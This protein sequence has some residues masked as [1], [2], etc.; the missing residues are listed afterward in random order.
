VNNFSYT[1]VVD[2]RDATTDHSVHGN[3][4]AQ[5]DVHQWF[6]NEAVIASGDHALVSS[7]DLNVHDSH[8]MTDS[9]N[10][11]NSLD[12]ATGTGSWAGAGP[13]GA[14]AVSPGPVSAGGD[15]A[16]GTSQWDVA[17]SFNTDVDLD[18]ADSINS[19]QDNAGGTPDHSTT[20]VPVATGDSSADDHSANDHPT[21]DYP[22]TNDAGIADSFHDDAAAAPGDVSI[23]D[24]FT[25]LE[26]EDS[27]PDSHETLDD[28]DSLDHSV[29]AD[30]DVHTVPPV[31]DSHIVL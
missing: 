11:D 23:A 3:I 6:Q 25:P 26:A 27:Y 29:D 8:T 5:G 22:T 19:N 17:D 9:F 28:Q 13:A 4:W 1:S 15:V 2:D 31:D 21:N 7:A 14:A 18:A 12:A 30:P 16:V 24:S 10:T 20:D